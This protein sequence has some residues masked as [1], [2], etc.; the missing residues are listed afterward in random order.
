MRLMRNTWACTSISIRT[1]IKTYCTKGEV[2][3]SVHNFCVPA[4][5]KCLHASKCQF[6]KKH[7]AKTQW[8]YYFVFKKNRISLGW[9]RTEC[10]TSKLTDLFP[11]LRPSF[12]RLQ[13]LL[14]PI[15][16]FP[17]SPYGSVTFHTAA[18]SFEDIA[19]GESTWHNPSLFPS[20]R[21]RRRR[22]LRSYI[23]FIYST[24]PYLSLFRI[25]IPPPA[26]VWLRR[27]SPYCTIKRLIRNRLQSKS[28]YLSCMKKSSRIFQTE[29]LILLNTL[30][31]F[32]LPALYFS[33]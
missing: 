17:P 24:V 26:E 27:L 7:K 3:R 29:S 21:R 19:S 32:L 20:C 2:Q 15:P 18:P 6:L 5:Y 30:F 13:L 1:R 25:W 9:N 31:V 28:S 33:K 4:T 16:S 23:L 14:F 8:Y 10:N 22:K 11:D 12:S